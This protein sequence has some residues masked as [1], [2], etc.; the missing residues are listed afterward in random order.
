M[1][2]NRYLVTN[3]IFIV[4]FKL[5]KKSPKNFYQETCLLFLSKF[6]IFIP[7]LFPNQLSSFLRN[8]TPCLTPIRNGGSSNWSS[9]IKFE[10]VKTC[11]MLQFL[12]RKLSQLKLFYRATREC[13]ECNGLQG[14]NHLWSCVKELCER[15]L[16]LMHQNV[17]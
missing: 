15:S 8:K 11:G 9:D 16:Y 1:L 17:S 4:D 10:G 13:V 5:W 14:E 3:T 6:L 7:K 12:F 2:N